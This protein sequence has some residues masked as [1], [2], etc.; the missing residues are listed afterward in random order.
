M[1]HMVM[2]VMS[3]APT[4]TVVGV[5]LFDLSSPLIYFTAPLNMHLWMVQPLCSTRRLFDEPLS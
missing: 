2:V 1:W 4:S 3:R 5:S